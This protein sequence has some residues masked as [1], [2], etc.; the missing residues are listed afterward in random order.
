MTT[1]TV[2]IDNE[3]DLPVLKEI[4]NRLGLTYQINEQ[5]DLCEEDKILYQRFKKTFKEIKDWEA[6][7]V[8]LQLAKEAIA[9]IE[10]ELRDGV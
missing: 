1:I 9:E 7:T 10:A 3:K 6:G 2:N 8:K 5:D 4:L